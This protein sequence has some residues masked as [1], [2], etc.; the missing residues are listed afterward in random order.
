MANPNSWLI[1]GLAVN[2]VVTLRSI[3][4]TDQVLQP[5]G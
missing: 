4:P 2:P 1:M 5:L 3:S